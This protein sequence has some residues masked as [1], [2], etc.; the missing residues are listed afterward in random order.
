MQAIAF[1]ARCPYELRDRVRVEQANGQVIMEITDII[2][3]MSART[4]QVKFILELNS[5]YKV[6]LNAAGKET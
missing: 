5:W 6:E 3:Q 2:T 1:Q 4:G